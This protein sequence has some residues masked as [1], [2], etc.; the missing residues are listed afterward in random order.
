MKDR[1]K[2]YERENSNSFFSI[3][4]RLENEICKIWNNVWN[5]WL[6]GE[7]DKWLHRNGRTEIKAPI[8]LLRGTILFLLFDST[9]H[10]E[11]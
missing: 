1:T 11:I 2:I 3:G 10:L 5:E 6:Q 8:E 9:D 4:K 7:M